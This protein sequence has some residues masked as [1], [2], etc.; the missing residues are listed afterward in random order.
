MSDPQFDVNAALGETYEYG[1]RTVLPAS[2]YPVVLAIG[3]TGTSDPKMV[4]VKVKGVVQTDELGNAIMT[5]GGETPFVELTMSVYEGPFA[6]EQVTRNVYVTPG[7]SGAAIGRW[8]G[9]CEAITGQKAAT[10]LMCG[11]FGIALPA[12]GSVRPIGEETVEQ[13]YRRGVRAALADG[14]FA[15]DAAKRLAFIA[16]LLNVVA[17]EGKRVVVKLG[18]EEYTSRDGQLRSNN[19]VDG[20][21]P[22]TDAKKGLAW[23][24][25]IEFPKQEITKKMMDKRAGEV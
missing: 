23:V 10:G 1:S 17:W 2:Y 4:E 15:M 25:A 18:I 16:A 9:A 13:A 8:L 24:R 3:D 20:F 12:G 19:V 21:I 11:K 5:E 7:K 22:L 6:G 14:F